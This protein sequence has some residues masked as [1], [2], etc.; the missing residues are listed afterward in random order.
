MDDLGSEGMP[1]R[2]IEGIAKE[3]DG[4]SKIMQHSLA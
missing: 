3:W 1:Q 2:K 4:K